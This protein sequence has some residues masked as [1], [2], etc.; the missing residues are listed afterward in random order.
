MNK[1][2]GKMPDILIGFIKNQGSYEM[3]IHFEEVQ[4]LVVS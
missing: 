1:H 3:I 4:F 2:S